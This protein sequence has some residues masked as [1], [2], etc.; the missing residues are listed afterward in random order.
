[1]G[2]KRVLCDSSF[3][4]EPSILVLSFQNLF[5]GSLSG[6]LSTILSNSKPFGSNFIITFFKLKNLSA[7]N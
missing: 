1:M 2:S 7:Q 5:G 3:L 4:K 6:D